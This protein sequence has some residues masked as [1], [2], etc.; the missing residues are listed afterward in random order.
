MIKCEIN[1][2]LFIKETILTKNNEKLLEKENYFELN[3]II[4][5][6]NFNSNENNNNINEIFE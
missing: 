1:D 3:K 5:S 4:C 2:I 6:Y